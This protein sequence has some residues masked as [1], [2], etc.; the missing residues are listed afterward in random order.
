M[1]VNTPGVWGVLKLKGLGHHGHSCTREVAGLSPES[2][3]PQSGSGE[4]DL[5]EFVVAL[6][7]VCRPSRTLDTVQLAFKASVAFT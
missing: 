7:V 4:M 6:S 1:L 5:R 2:L 3:S